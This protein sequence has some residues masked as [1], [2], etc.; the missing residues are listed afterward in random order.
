MTGATV[1]SRMREAVQLYRELGFYEI[2]AYRPNPME[3]TL[4]LELLLAQPRRV[5]AENFHSKNV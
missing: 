1:S 2:A 4:Y 3:G 5:T